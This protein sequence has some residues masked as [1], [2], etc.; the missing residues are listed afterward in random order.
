MCECDFL[1]RII[2]RRAALVF[3]QLRGRSQE[4]SERLRRI[5]E[6]GPRPHASERIAFGLLRP[7]SS[8][9]RQRLIECL[10][11]GRS[12]LAKLGDRGRQRYH[13]IQLVPTIANC[14]DP[15]KN[16]HSE[17]TFAIELAPV[18]AARPRRPAPE[19]RPPQRCFR[20]VRARKR[21]SARRSMGQIIA[22]CCK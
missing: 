3:D 7:S 5:S 18:S 4:R 22:G 14:E 10:V 6:F 12:G 19:R 8:Q 9:L 15:R 16:V 17:C 21:A 13:G 1:V 2:G 20:S 11:G